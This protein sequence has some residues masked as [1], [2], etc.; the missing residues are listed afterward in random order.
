MK[1]SLSV[2]LAAF[3]S[4]AACQNIEQLVPE[5]ADDVLSAHIEQDEVTKT[6]LGESNNILW[7][8][9][10]QIVAFMKTSYGHKYQIQSSF[11]GKTYANF[12]KIS[13]V[14][15]DDLSAGM[16]WDH[17]VAYYP[18]A[19]GIE[20]VMS[21]VNYTLDVVI[22]AEQTYAENSFGNGYFP[23]VAVSED[24]D[25]TFKNV[26][27]GMKLQLKG[28]QKVTS[29]TVQG[30]NNEVL[31]GTATVTAYTD[32]ETKPSITMTG[33]DAASKSVTLDCGAGVQLSESTVTEFIIALPPVDFTE[34]FAVTVTDSHGNNQIVE[35]D[36]ENSVLRSSLLIMPPVKLGDSGEQSNVK[37]SLLIAP[38]TGTKAGSYS[39]HVDIV[40]YEVWDSDW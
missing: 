28:T 11:V 25:I 22:P 37:F 38:D 2:L 7:S 5:V 34:G 31:S 15:G 33:T 16:E 35:T 13:S 21:D 18:Y 36:E 20:C 23:M 8:E 9:D 4:L 1:K 30:K 29:I 6:V 40:Y 19:E 10:D 17:N 14:S 27:G 12:S 39:E 3:L 32:G 24:N 26:C